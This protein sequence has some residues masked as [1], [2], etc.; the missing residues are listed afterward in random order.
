MW[1]FLKPDVKGYRGL[2][3]YGSCRSSGRSQLPKLAPRHLIR[4]YERGCHWRQ[5]YLCGCCCHYSW[6]VR[7]ECR[8][9]AIL[10]TSLVSEGVRRSQ[11][12]AQRNWWKERKRLKSRNVFGQQNTS[13]WH[14]RLRPCTSMCFFLWISGIPGSFSQA[15]CCSEMR[16][17]SIRL[18]EG[19]QLWREIASYFCS[20]MWWMNA[21][22]IRSLELPFPPLGKK[23]M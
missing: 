20:Q 16:A 2:L 3:T 10:G 21:S 19:L 14:C 8:S 9:T 18:L 13:L 5:M 23:K 6:W 1:E 11:G 4:L 7:R 22:S 17:N 12:K 15:K